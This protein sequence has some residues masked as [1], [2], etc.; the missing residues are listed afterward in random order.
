MTEYEYRNRLNAE[1]KKRTYLQRQLALC[2]DE[3]RIL[4]NRIDLMQRKIEELQDTVL[5]T[6]NYQ[7]SASE[8][9]QN[10]VHRLLGE[11]KALKELIEYYQA[12]N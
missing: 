1:A 4:K 2:I 9:Y 10:E 6:L 3:T 8:E 12:K 11:N 5:R 7:G